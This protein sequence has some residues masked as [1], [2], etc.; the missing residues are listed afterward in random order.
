VA[1]G[2]GLLIPKSEFLTIKERR[3]LARTFAGFTSSKSTAGVSISRTST[4]KK[5][6]HFFGVCT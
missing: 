6:H 1:E 3:G 2:D 4:D 5:G